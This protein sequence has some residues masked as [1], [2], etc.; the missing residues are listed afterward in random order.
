[1][2]LET[3]FVQVPNDP[4][5]INAIN[6][7]AAVW[8]WTVQSIQVTDSKITYEGDSHGWVSD[9]GAYIQTEIITEHTN[10]A[11][12]TYQR[13]LDAPSY[14]E[15]KALED[16]YNQ[17]DSTS[18]LNDEE[19]AEMQSIINAFDRK[20]SLFKILLIAAVFLTVWVLSVKSMQIG[21][22]YP[23]GIG[24]L[25]CIVLWNRSSHF[26]NYNN[27]ARYRQL[28]SIND[29]RRDHIKAQILNQAKSI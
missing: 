15:L 14:K 6:N 8:G 7:L 4:Q 18:Y 11:S 22:I 27:N 17:C 23:I 20:H 5:T 19:D 25:A 2:R 1:M 3:K 13:D 16:K 10:Y 24:I 9:Y 12:I 28:M 21:S 26:D 29:E